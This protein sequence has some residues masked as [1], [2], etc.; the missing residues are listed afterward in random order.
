M[1]NLVNLD[2][3]DQYTDMIDQQLITALEA[4][5]RLGVSR[6][7]L[8]AYV[9]RGMIRSDPEPGPGRRRRYN[10]EDVQA[11][12]D[13]KARGRG[14]EA[15]ASQAMNFGA[16]VLESGLTLI[17]DD[18]L[19]YRGKDACALA[20]EASLEDVARL[21]WNIDSDPFADAALPEIDESLRRGWIASA[22]LAPMDRCLAMLPLAAAQDTRAWSRDSKALAVTGT[23]VARLLA[24]IVAARPP[25]AAPL[26]R[27]I[28]TAWKLDEHGADLVRAALVLSADHELNASTFAVRIAASTGATPWGATV[29]GLA[30]LQGPYHG[31]MTRRVASMM[32]ALRGA[33][34]LDRAVAERIESGARIPGFGHRL[35]PD[36]DVRAQFLLE[37]L[38][39]RL[40]DREEVRYARRLITSV[41]KVT[42]L[43]PT[44]DV[45]TVAIERACGMPKGAALGLFLLGRSIGWIAHFIEQTESGTLIRPRARYVG[46]EA[47][48]FA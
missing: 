5:E 16:P 32:E 1:I 2:N 15:V 14:A 42:G 9:S 8:Y 20:A 48:A 21:L 37:R 33:T 12:L 43:K 27:Q 30:V 23:R 3:I 47:P 28:A 40:G 34:D 26:H 46:P 31:G 6:E 45:A 29:A 35:Y 11:L 10:A 39:H 18:R 7:T 13:R 22:R 41:T 4:S 24:A 36:G 25:A 38:S 19:L 44:I 17:D